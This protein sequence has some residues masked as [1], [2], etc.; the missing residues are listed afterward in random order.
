LAEE[1]SGFDRVVFLDA[2]T[3]SLHPVIEPVPAP[4]MSRSPLTHAPEPAEIVALSRALFGFDGEA[5]ICRIPARDFSP[6]ETLGSCEL[7]SINEAAG[8][9]QGLIR[10]R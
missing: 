9:L 3:R 1:I 10:I 6:G 4:P 8:G 2:D 5:L 7:L